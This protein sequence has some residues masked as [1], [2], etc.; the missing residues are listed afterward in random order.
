VKNGPRGYSLSDIVNYKYLFISTDPVALDSAGAAV[1]AREGA[2]FRTAEDV[3]YIKI[4][5]QYG[6]GRT[7]LDQMKIKR[8]TI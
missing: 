3:R 4:A 5:K 6:L 2:G 7:D 8:I 1:L